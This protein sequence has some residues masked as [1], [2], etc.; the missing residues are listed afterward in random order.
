MAEYFS[1]PRLQFFDT[2]TN[3]PLSGGAVYVYVA[4]TTTPLAT[5]PS[6]D[7]LNALTNAQTHPVIL[8]S[9][10]EATIVLSGAS[11]VVLKDAP[12]GNTIWTVDDVNISTGDIL[13]SNGNEVIKL[14]AV[15]SAVNE[16]T[17]TN[18]GTGD[19]PVI[20]SS[21]NDTNVNLN[22]RS[23]GTG[24]LALQSAAAPT[25]VGGTLTITGTTTTSG[26]LTASGG[27]TAASS[28]IDVLPAGV[29]A[30][31][32]AASAPAG[33][34]LCDG[35]AI[36]R[37]TYSVLFAAIGTTFGAGDGSTTFNLP[38]QARRTIV[39]AGGSGTAT[40]A[41]TVGSTGGSETHTLVIGEIPAHTHT[42][43]SYDLTAAFYAGANAARTNVNVQASGSAG[44]GGSHNNM[45]PSLVLN[46]IIKR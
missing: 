3:L 27:V 42:E 43:N 31:T 14:V 10:G 9:R 19:T 18:A 32:A 20:A 13:D 2:A 6:I 16:I 34:F 15:S 46:M 45:Q 4:G 7:D 39:G 22:I 26:M 23:K 25:T 5:Y 37:T 30:Y 24:T 12:D 35:A 17:V 41:N 36:S 29:V 1:S 11:K 33:W 44:G 28:A 8:D 40:L 21:G 38:T